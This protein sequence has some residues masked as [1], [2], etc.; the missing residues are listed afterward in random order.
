V[1]LSSASV[2]RVQARL[3]RRGEVAR[4]HRPRR[5]RMALLTARS[6][7]PTV[8]R[9]RLD[10]AFH[11]GPRADEAVAALAGLSSVPG[12]FGDGIAAVLTVAAVVGAQAR[13]SGWRLRMPLD[14]VVV[15]AL[16][17]MTEVDRGMPVD[18]AR[19]TAAFAETM[20]PLTRRTLNPARRQRAPRRS[21]AR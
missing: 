2:L 19:L 7:V 3:V 4:V 1:I 11:E 17:T 20:E 21:A 8:R 16:E 5:L 6:L 13:A 14:E 12:V 18:Y 15:R 10:D 9:M